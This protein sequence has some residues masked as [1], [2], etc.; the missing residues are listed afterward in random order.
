MR[1]IQ[2]AQR[3]AVDLKTRSEV[4]DCESEDAFGSSVK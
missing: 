1:A 2:L 3:A 4:S